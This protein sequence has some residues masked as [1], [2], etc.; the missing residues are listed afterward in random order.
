M[1]RWRR[2]T[3]LQGIEAAL[4]GAV[5]TALVID[6]FAV[7]VGRAPEDEIALPLGKRRHR[8]AQHHRDDVPFEE[9]R[10]NEGVVARR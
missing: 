3:G 10:K 5:R 8:D 9:A 7:L 6:Q 4:L 1:H 2:A